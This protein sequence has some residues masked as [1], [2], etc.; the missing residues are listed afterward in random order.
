MPGWGWILQ[1][2]ATQAVKTLSSTE[3]GGAGRAA[4]THCPSAE[5]VVGDACD[6]AKTACAFCGKTQ[7]CLQKH[8]L[9]SGRK[10]LVLNPWKIGTDSEVR[11]FE[12]SECQGLRQRI[13]N[14]TG[15]KLPSTLQSLAETLRPIS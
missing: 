14:M 5:F 11:P 9:I 8:F 1:Y 6:L 4:Q 12:S 13:N 2:R 15:L 10:R 7:G 3:E